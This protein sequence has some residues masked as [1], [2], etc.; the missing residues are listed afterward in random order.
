[1]NRLKEFLENIEKIHRSQNYQSKEFV[2][3]NRDNTRQFIKA[4]Q[5]VTKLD[6]KDKKVLD[7]GFGVGDAL[8]KFTEEGAKP[9]GICINIEE[10]ESA[11]KKGYEVYK[12]DQN[13][14]TFEDN[15]FDIIW[16]RHCLEH[17][18]MPYYTLNEYKRVMKPG[19]FIY[20]EVPAPETKFHHET[21]IEHFSLFT[22]GV[23]TELMRRSFTVISS[24]T[25]NMI[26]EFGKDYNY[27]FILKK[28]L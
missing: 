14:M 17:S 27:A 10:I 26:N 19:A 12:M 1:M 5:I 9:V 24:V 13:F 6:F 20:V 2:K 28:E 23:W 11:T 16:S 8:E 15:T 25:N 7:I 21:N 22:I 4:F 18:I 3:A